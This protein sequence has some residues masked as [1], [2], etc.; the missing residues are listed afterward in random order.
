M[1]TAWRICG[2]LLKASQPTWTWC[3]RI[4]SFP[5]V[6]NPPFKK[7]TLLLW[8]VS[9][10]DKISLIT[11]QL[12]QEVMKSC[13]QLSQLC[14]NPCGIIP[15]DLKGTGR[16]S[17]S[18]RWLL[19][20]ASWAD[21]NRSA[22][23][24]R[25]WPGSQ[26][27]DKLNGKLLCLGWIYPKQIIFSNSIDKKKKMTRTSY[28]VSGYYRPCQDELVR[29]AFWRQLWSLRRV[30]LHQQ[31]TIE[32][33]HHRTMLRCVEDLSCHVRLLLMTTLELLRQMK[34]ICKQI[35]SIISYACY[36]CLCQTQ[37]NWNKQLQNII[38]KVWITAGP[39]FQAMMTS[40]S[41]FLSAKS[42]FW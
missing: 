17:R 20:S 35:S 6:H 27:L 29:H 32:S 38:C 23:V 4:C 30:R 39:P 3:C 11:W 7:H 5:L 18:S 13:Q 19:P 40:H 2:S 1:T 34:P 41:S 31:C 25:D 9:T 14:V 37:D 16:W 42:F 28:Q 21:E 12:L 10:D 36:M 24:L 8:E 22:Y 26:K 33:F 15:S